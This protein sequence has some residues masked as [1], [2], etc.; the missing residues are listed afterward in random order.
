M[1]DIVSKC[2]N[3]RP[4]TD[5]NDFLSDRNTADTRV[6]VNSS[7]TYSSKSA[8]V[9]TFSGH[10]TPKSAMAMAIVAMPVAPPLNI[11]F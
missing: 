5:G 11:H 7:S 10:S 3:R 1:A 4:T 6:Y 2:Y 8:M 9:K